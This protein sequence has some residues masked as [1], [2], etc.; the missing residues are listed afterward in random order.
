MATKILVIE[1]EKDIRDTITYALEEYLYEVVSSEDAGILRSLDE[2]KPDLIMLD[3]WLTE[4][5]SDANGQQISR[6]LKNDPKTAHIPIILIS[7]MSNVKELATAGQ[8]D[9]YLQKPFDLT[10]LVD[11]VNRFVAPPVR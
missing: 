2:I 4:W 8:A 11:I 7:A 10:D 9:A 1:D 3:N 6:D 5:T